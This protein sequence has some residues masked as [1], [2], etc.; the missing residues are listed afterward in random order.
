MVRAIVLEA[1]L[2]AL[3]GSA[4]GTALGWI[5]ALLVNRHYQDVYRTPLAFALVTPGT[6]AFAAGLSLVLGVLAGLLAARR[7]VRVPPLVLLGR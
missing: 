5:A 6:V 3:V 2:V 1:S 7:L 4:L